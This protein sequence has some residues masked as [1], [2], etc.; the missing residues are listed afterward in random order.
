[1]VEAVGYVAGSSGVDTRASYFSDILGANSIS[2]SYTNSKKDIRGAIVSV[3]PTIF[4][5]QD[6]WNK[7]K[8]NSP[9]ESNSPYVAA[10]G[11]DSIGNVL[12]ND[13][14]LRA[15]ALYKKNILSKAKLGILTGSGTNINK[16]NKRTISGE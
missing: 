15:S 6:T 16:D 9:F 5:V 8:I 2:T 12:I 10:R 11:S 1:M 3:N 13:L 4:L 7:S 14:E